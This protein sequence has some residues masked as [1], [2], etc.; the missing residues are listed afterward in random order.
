MD[1]LINREVAAF[2]RRSIVEMVQYFSQHMKVAVSGKDLGVLTESALIRNLITH[3]GAVADDELER[4]N[5]QFVSGAQ[6][7][8]TSDI[9]LY[10]LAVRALAK[11]LD[12]QLVAKYGIK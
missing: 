4:L 2:T 5:A 3:N 7:K 8:L 11:S 10:G 12:E 6:I 9:H 1:F